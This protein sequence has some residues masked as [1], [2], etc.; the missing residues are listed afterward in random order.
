[1]DVTS[2]PPEAPRV[3]LRQTTVK[4]WANKF[5]PPG[6]SVSYSAIHRF[7]EVAEPML[8]LLWKQA[9]DELNAENERNAATTDPSSA[10]KVKPRKKLTGKHVERARRRLP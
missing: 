7:I 9:F 5:R 2:P 4:E 10:Y 1:M 8:G 6:V 3:E